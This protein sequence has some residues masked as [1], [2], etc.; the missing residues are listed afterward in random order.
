MNEAALYCGMDLH[1]D[2]VFVTLMDEARRIVFERRLPNDLETIREALEPYRKR[3][4]ALAVESTYNWYW[5]VDGLK[6]LKYPASLANPARMQEN[7]GLKQA[8]DKTDARFIARQLVN[9]TLPEGYIY[10]EETRGVRDMMRRRMRLTHARSGE[11]ISL[12]SLIA[13]HTGRAMNTQEL[14]ACEIG[15]VLAGQ[16]HALIMAQASFRHIEFLDREIKALEQAVMA[17]LPDRDDYKRLMTAPGIGPVLAR[18]ILLE[19]GPITRFRAAGNYASYCR[20]VKSEHTTNGKK[21]GECNGK[22]GNKYLAWAYVEAATFAVR[23]S[24]EIRAWFQRKQ[25]RSGKRVIA[26]KALANKMAKACYFMLRDGKDFDV[27]R[28][29]G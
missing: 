10:P 6:R 13:R 22:S 11:W 9:G 5:L 17:E 1:G 28:L 24:P 8:N 3:I 21:K 29:T 25:A 19:N 12:E 14:R 26:I 7:L 4:R 23:H 27:K 2:N 18:T 15:D 16:P 20:A